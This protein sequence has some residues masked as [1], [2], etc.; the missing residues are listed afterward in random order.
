MQRDKLDQFIQKYA[1]GG[2]VN[3]TK[4]NCKNRILSTSFVTPDKNLLGQVAVK[5]FNFEDCEFGVYSTDQLQKLLGVLGDNIDLSITKFND[6]P[7]ALNV[8]N[9]T[10]SFDYVLADVAVIP[11]ANELK[12]IPKFDTKI[13]I[14][15]HFIHTFIKG[16]TALSEVDT[17]SIINENN[18]VQVV[19][20]YS[21][22]NTN[23]VTI[24]VVSETVGLTDIISF[25]AE[26]F[27]EILI[28]NK[29]CTTAVLEISNEG[30]ARIVFNIN[31][32]KSVYYVVATQ[33]VD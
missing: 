25:N 14:D 16:K 24:P 33:G 2:L 29:E 15:T 32:F 9:G 18:Q 20:G 13:K 1:L 23:R 8:K 11:T 31:D 10:I 5:D 4:W 28:A 21:S 19:I 27:K 12:R 6:K 26:L 22:I 7:M 30:L 17:F 3:S